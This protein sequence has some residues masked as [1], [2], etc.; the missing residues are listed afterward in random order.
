MK[1]EF[2]KHP[3]Y[4][5]EHDSPSKIGEKIKNPDIIVKACPSVVVRSSNGQDQMIAGTND[6]G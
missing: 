6:S 2:I 5:Q 4:E 1:Y 3:K